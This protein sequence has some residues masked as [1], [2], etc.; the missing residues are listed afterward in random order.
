MLTLSEAAR[1]VRAR[2]LSPVELTEACL[3]R[4]E[5]L[6]PRLNAFITVRADAALTEAREAEAEL[7]RAGPK[8]PLHGIPIALKDNIDTAGLRTT[9]ASGVLKDNVPQDDAETV[10]R[11]KAAGAIILGKLN[12][13]EFAYGGSSVIS[14]FGPVRNPWNP[15][16][17]TGGSSGG[18]AAAVAA[19]LCYATLGTDTGGSIRQPAAFCGV[20]GL[21]PSYGL[22]SSRGVIP[23]A[24][25]MDHVGPLTRTV[26]DAAVML[27]A[28]AGYD[29]QDPTS[30]RLPVP[31]YVEAL[32]ARHAAPRLGIPRAFF[33]DALQPDVQGAL[34]DAL[35]VLAQLGG[36]QQEIEPLAED[37][38]YSS[39]Q[40]AYSD[41]LAAEAYSY[42]RDRIATTPELY[43]A[44]TLDR[45]Q[46][47]ARIDS[48]TYQ[49]SQRVLDQVR[50]SISRVFDTID[51]LITP[52]TPGASLTIADLVADPATLRS[53]EVT[54]LRNTRPFN[55][56]G[57][58]SLSIPCGFTR[59]GLAIGMQITGPRG[60]EAAVLRLAHAYEQAT[61]W[62]ARHPAY[63][64]HGGP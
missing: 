10:R 59:D 24:S 16:Y 15:A 29:A 2:E 22:V 11:L 56:L 34:E 31:D 35:A 37:A 47:G 30:A 21:K 52:T 57:L 32:T 33:Y 26:A 12:L 4:I 48:T 41:I 5:A 49:A 23:L 20:V 43:Q 39:I 8:G 9:A 46:G 36:S 40:R 19:G 13:H 42:H 25:S 50:Q 45:V 17:C 55:L 3:R 7:V 6:N 51:L 28:I 58:P 27:Q 44:E 63:G 53:K 61:D 60:G 64:P 62:H 14:Y 18:S 54:T 38:K 1:L